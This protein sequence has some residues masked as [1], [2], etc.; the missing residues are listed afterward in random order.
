MLLL[1]SKLCSNLPM[2]VQSREEECGWEQNRKKEKIM[3]Q[4]KQ[5]KK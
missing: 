5:K 3:G 1:C 2:H 4:M